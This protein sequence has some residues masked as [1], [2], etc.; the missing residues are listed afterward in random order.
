MAGHRHRR[1][2]AHLGAHR[3]GQDAGRLPVGARPAR[4]Q[5][6]ALRGEADAARLRLAAQGA[7]LRHRAQPPGSAEGH[8]RRHRRRHPHRRHAPARARGHATQAAR[9]AHHDARVAVPHPHLAGARDAH[10][11]R[12]GDR[13]RDPR[14][15]PD[16]A[17][18]APRAHARA[19]RGAGRARGPAHRPQ[20]HAVS[21]RGGRALPRRAAAHV[22]DRR[23][24]SAQA[25]R[26]ED[27]RARR[28]D[29]RARQR[30]RHRF[31]CGRD[32]PTRQSI[33]PAIYPELLELVRQHT[34]TIV[35]VNNRRGA[36][37]LALRLNELARERD[38]PRPP[39][40]ARPRGAAGGRGDAQVGRAA[41]PRGHVVAGAGHRHGR[42]RPRAPGRVAEVGVAAASSASAAPATTWAT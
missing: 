17:R 18:R 42:G 20:R 9:R 32:G 4:G 26:P 27:P 12:V 13:R 40:L 36:E 37:R 7:V 24:R 28:V 29:G 31:R 19:P 35:F 14:R 10:R 8:R 2:R 5:P 1:A 33:W 15:G 16:Q 41:V 22:H 25:A 21:A 23:H 11:R 39:R 38:R 30:R 34:S 3:L 6:A